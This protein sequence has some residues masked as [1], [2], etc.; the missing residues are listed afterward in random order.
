[1]KPSEIRFLFFPI[2]FSISF[3]VISAPDDQNVE[4]IL[5]YINKADENRNSIIDV[6]K[7][8]KIE[9]NGNSIIVTKSQ[10]SEVL[11]NKYTRVNIK[12]TG[13][14]FYSTNLPSTKL[15]IHSDNKTVKLSTKNKI[16]AESDFSLVLPDLHNNSK[17]VV[18]SDGS[19]I[20]PDNNEITDVAVQYFN[21]S[22]RILTILNSFNSPTEYEYRVNLPVGGKIEKI[23]NGSVIIFNKK[24][25]LIG[26]FA[27]PWAIDANGKSIPTHYEIQGNIVI[28]IVEHLSDNTV[29]PVVA[30]PWLWKDL[31]SSATW[32]SSESKWTLKVTP[33]KWARLNAGGY[34]IGVYGW[35][36]LYSK[37]KNVG[38]GIKKNLNGMK[39]QFI[40]HQ[41]VVA[42][43]SPN[44]STWNLDEYRAD[45]G[46]LQ[47]V[48]SS[49]NPGSPNIFD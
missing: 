34:L 8:E 21:D 6:D 41:Q 49:C 7:K 18:S 43:V 39:D 12:N 14:K 45:V 16:Q 37:Y 5:M 47:T 19:I 44:K 40:C 26:G 33:T 9:V 35:N 10:K 36:E 13:N 2:L 20:Y 24:G 31:I 38:R 28:Q 17:G 32:S 22:A 25:D 48:N 27:S 4:K 1:M 11:L 42:I 46:Y 30:D 3:S 23:E 29:Y 15:L